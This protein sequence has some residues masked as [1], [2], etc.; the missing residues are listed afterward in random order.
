MKRSKIHVILV[1]QREMTENGAKMIFEEKM[2]KIC[3]KC[4]KTSVQRF[5]KLY[6]K[7]DK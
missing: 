2:A 3:P 6:K 1:S 5:K 7:Q 4:Q